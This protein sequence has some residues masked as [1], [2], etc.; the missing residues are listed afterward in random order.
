MHEQEL[1]SRLQAL[2][3]AGRAAP[4][5]AAFDAVRRRG[6]RKLQGAT[7]LVLALLGGCGSGGS[8]RRWLS[9]IA[10]ATSTSFRPLCCEWSRSMSNARSAS[11]E[12][13]AIRMPFACSIVEREEMAS[14]KPSAASCWPYAYDLR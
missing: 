13:R 7:A 9:T 3:A 12:C 6:R 1:R 5:P 4:G 11:I 2:A 14:R 8:S 10:C